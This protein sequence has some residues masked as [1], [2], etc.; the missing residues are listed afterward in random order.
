M[1]PGERA[2]VLRPRSGKPDV[3]AAMRAGDILVHHPYDSFAGS[4]ERF[5]EQAV[6]DP[7][8]LAIK[9]TVYRTSD[10]SALVPL[11]IQAAERGKQA[12]C[13]VELKARFDERRNIGW[14]RSLEEAGAHV[15]HGLP[16]LKTHAKALL[17]VRREGTG[18]RHYVHVGTGNYHAKTARLYED[19]GLFTTDRDDRGRRGRRSSTRSPARRAP[20][21]YRKA[22]VAPE[23]MRD[24]LLAEIERDR[25][26][27]PRRPGRADRD[28]D[29]LAGGPA[30]HPRAVRGI[31]GRR[32]G[33]PQRARHLLPARRA[34][35]GVSE[36]I[37]VVSIVGRF[38]EHSRIY[39]FHRDDERRY[40]IG[41][42]DL[43]PR[44][45]DTRVEL[46]TPGRGARAARGAG[47][48]ARA[49]LRR[50]HASPGTCARTARW[51]RRTG[52]DA[53]RAP[54]A[55][56]AGAGARRGGLGQRQR[57][58]ARLEL[59]QP[60]LAVQP[61]AEAGERAV[62]ADHAVAG[63]DHR[64]RVPAVGEARPHVPGRGRPRAAPARRS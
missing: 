58:H 11:L 39:G 30:L 24:G 42:A 8:V 18:V 2:A 17:V 37:R 36:N 6:N 28:E 7:N 31:A 33:R 64:Q 3:F 15:V 4:V 35:P 14:A 21:G 44:N 29:E 46:L 25:R 45:L 5:V 56:G 48:H 57:G 32:A 61:A 16:G 63:H 52:G 12:V 59:Q 51:E 50:R 62:G 20:P 54:R 60:A 40:Y 41:S 34:C 9:M 26:G 22:L 1:D 47:G 43:M 38:L 23:R 13:L 53:L 10:D 19:F 55:D 27:A 49:L